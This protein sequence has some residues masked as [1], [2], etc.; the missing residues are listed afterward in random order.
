MAAMS[1][2]QLAE[3]VQNDPDLAAK[4]K[5]DPHG[6]LLAQAAYVSDKQVYRMAIGGL[7]AVILLVV[8][9]G[10]IAELWTV[11]ANQPKKALPDGLLALGTTA[12]G[13]LGGLFISSPN[14]K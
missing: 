9:G 13:V 7:I 8:I 1:V 3:K 11:G 2:G 14:D 12:L 4:L 10:F 5:E 6:T